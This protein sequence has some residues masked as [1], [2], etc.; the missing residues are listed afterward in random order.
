[1]LNRLLA[2]RGA[3]PMCLVALLEGNSSILTLLVVK[4]KL[5]CGIDLVSVYLLSGLFTLNPN[6]IAVTLLYTLGVSLGQRHA[7][8]V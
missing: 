8:R 3:A 6:P 2:I 1:M 4:G 7:F 5:H